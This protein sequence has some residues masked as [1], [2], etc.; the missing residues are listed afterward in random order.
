[1]FCQPVKVNGHSW[2]TLRKLVITDGH[3]HEI[4]QQGKIG[5]AV[6]FEFTNVAMNNST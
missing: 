4:K 2:Q 3:R 1:M 6:K 5:L